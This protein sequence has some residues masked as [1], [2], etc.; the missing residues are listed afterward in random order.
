M[1]ALLTDFLYH[2]KNYISVNHAPPLE[3]ITKVQLRRIRTEGS[4]WR[5]IK[6]S[7]GRPEFKSMS[8]EQM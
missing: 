3:A 8:S 7:A 1:N 2:N 4:E 5:A 6:T